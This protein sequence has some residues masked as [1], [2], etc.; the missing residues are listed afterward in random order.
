MGNSPRINQ[1][2]KKKV[3]VACA[4]IFSGIHFFNH[5]PPVIKTTH[6]YSCFE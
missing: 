5:F 2:I 1:K 3:R 6:F 4:F